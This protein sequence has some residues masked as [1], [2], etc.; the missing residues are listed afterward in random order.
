MTPTRV[1]VMAE[2]PFC[3]VS[4]MPRVNPTIFSSTIYLCALDNCWGYVI[5]GQKAAEKKACDTASRT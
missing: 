1:V 4:M 5:E 3:V 2:K